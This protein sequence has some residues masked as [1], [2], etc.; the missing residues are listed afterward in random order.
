MS[1]LLLGQSLSPH[2]ITT[3]V[4]RPIRYE[5]F[6]KHDSWRDEPHSITKCPVFC[7]LYRL[8]MSWFLQDTR[9]KCSDG[10]WSVM[11]R[12]LLAVNDTDSAIERSK[13]MLS[14]EGWCA[15]STHIIW[16]DDTP[17]SERIIRS[18]PGKRELNPLSLTMRERIKNNIMCSSEIC[19]SS[20][21]SMSTMIKFI[22]PRGS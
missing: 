8:S 14:Q 2:E 11:S 6:P 15:V 3:V 17:S 7:R 13:W 18:F 1:T 10:P 21:F 20:D 12:E 16:T 22:I 19:K 4:S 5:L 9:S